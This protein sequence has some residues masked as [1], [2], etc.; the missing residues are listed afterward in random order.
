MKIPYDE[1]DDHLFMIERDLMQHIPKNL[2]N[3]FN[4]NL[5]L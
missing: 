4:G 1:Q 2:A 3:T 5:K